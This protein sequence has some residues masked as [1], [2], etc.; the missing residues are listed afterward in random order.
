[1][2]EL[3]IAMLILSVFGVHEARRAK[4]TWKDEDKK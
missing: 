3:M 4:A 1:M 2:I